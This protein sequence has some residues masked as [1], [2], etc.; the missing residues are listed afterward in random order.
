[1]S[2]PELLERSSDAFF[3]A[4]PEFTIGDSL[5]ATADQRVIRIVEA[6]IPQDISPQ[7]VDLAQRNDVRVRAKAL[8]EQCRTRAY[9]GQDECCRTSHG[10]PSRA[11]LAILRLRA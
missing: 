10:V 5:A 3:H 4:A 6:A 2:Q 9:V 7:P 11:S 8:I 1:L